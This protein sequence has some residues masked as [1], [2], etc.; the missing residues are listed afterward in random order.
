[1][2]AWAE[3]EEEGRLVPVL[4]TARLR[5]E[6]I[7]PAHVRGMIALHS[8]RETLRFIGDGEP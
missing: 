6:P 2:L 5:L 4:R 7:S 3:L 1:M 8:D